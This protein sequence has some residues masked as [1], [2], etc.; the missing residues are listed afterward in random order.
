MQWLFI[1][2]INMHCPVLHD[3]EL[4]VAGS[5]FR[6]GP[7]GDLNGYLLE[8]RHDMPIGGL[9]RLQ[10]FAVQESWQPRL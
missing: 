7:G 9:D 6:P 1:F 8:P 5:G 10:S 4:L 3:G 2:K